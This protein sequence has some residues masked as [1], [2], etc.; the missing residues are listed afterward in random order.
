[1]KKKLH[2]MIIPV[3]KSLVWS[4]VIVFAFSHVEH[5]YQV[6]YSSDYFNEVGFPLKYHFETTFSNDG[7][8]G[9]SVFNLLID[10][11]LFFIVFLGV[12]SFIRR[13]IHRHKPSPYDEK[14]G[15]GMQ[16]SE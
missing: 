11:V 14:H 10:I 5:L 3:I 7:L 8:H 4:I 12:G 9:L 15:D 13:K 2:K 1:M 6:R 16:K